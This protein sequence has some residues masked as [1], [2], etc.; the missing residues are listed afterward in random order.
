MAKKKRPTGIEANGEA[1]GVTATPMQEVSEPVVQEVSIVVEAP[2]GVCDDG[3]AANHIEMG[4]MM[5]KQAAALKRIRC[6]LA[7]SAMRT[8]RRD[9]NHRDG[10][11]VD[12]NADALR[13]LLDQYAN[14]Y[15][16]ETGEDIMKGLTF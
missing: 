10:K 12:S 16:D 4:G 1:G 13:W 8:Q 11:V 3:Y 2:M 14:K 5:P 15:Y 9:A 7:D 6:S